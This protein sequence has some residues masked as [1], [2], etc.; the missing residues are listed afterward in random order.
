MS[1]VN[2][3]VASPVVSFTA[4]GVTLT[5]TP[6]A[7]DSGLLKPLIAA[8]ATAR[9]G[10]VQGGAIPPLVIDGG[11]PPSTGSVIDGGGP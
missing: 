9:V 6:I 10:L 2:L 5:Q 7:V 4:D 1:N 8:A 3:S 11:N